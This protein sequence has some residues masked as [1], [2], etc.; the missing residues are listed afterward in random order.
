PRLFSGEAALGPGSGSEPISALADPD[1][2]LDLT[3]PGL[4]VLRVEWSEVAPGHRGLRLLQR[5][6]G[7]DTLEVRFVR[8][9]P[10]DPADDPLGSLVRAPLRPG[11]S[12]VVKVHRDGWLIA[13]A[14]LARETLD[15]LIQ[16]TGAR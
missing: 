9:G 2:A 7:G 6:E 3:V 14:P 15:A 16:R 12:Q 10:G 1:E 13:R 11:W 5:L 4:E 8:P